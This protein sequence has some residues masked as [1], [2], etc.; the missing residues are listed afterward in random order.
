MFSYKDYY[1]QA[2]IRKD[3]VRQAEKYRQIKEI[4]NTEKESQKKEPSLLLLS[5]ASKLVRFSDALRAKGAD[6]NLAS[7]G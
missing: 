1:A 2:E 4:R 7:E 3:Q 6:L 5:A